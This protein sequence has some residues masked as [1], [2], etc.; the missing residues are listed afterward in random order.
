MLRP[1]RHAKKISFGGGEP[2]FLAAE[3]KFTQYTPAVQEESNEDSQ[4][5]YYYEN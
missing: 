1:P 2:D 3:E 5:N 4:L